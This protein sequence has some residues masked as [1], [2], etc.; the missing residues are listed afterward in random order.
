MTEELRDLMERVAAHAPGGVD[1][2][3]LWARARRSRRRELVIAPI[4]AI[5]VVALVV[6][7]VIGAVG[8]LHSSTVE[9][10]APTHRHGA[11]EVPSRIY[12]MPES[13]GAVTTDLALGTLAAVYLPAGQSR[14][15]A[16][17]AVTGA[18]H[19]LAL[20]GFADGG[21][22]SFALSP[23]G[24]A[25]AYA[26]RAKVPK[27]SQTK[28]V[29]SGIA[30]VEL[31]DG[32]LTRYRFDQGKG[33]QVTM[34][35]WSPNGRWLAF[36]YGVAS[37]LTAGGAT[38]GAW[39]VG[40]MDTNASTADAGVANPGDAL[41]TMPG[42]I[43]STNSAVGV[44]NDGTVI[45]TA[46]DVRLWNPEQKMRRF[47]LP[48]PYRNGKFA[49]AATG[50]LPS[51]DGQHVV[52]TL[53]AAQSPYVL[54][55]AS[56]QMQLLSGLSKATY[57]AFGWVGD[58]IAGTYDSAADRIDLELW[59][60]TGKEQV[61]GSIDQDATRDLSIATGLMDA[62]RPTASFPAPSWAPSGHPW[63][64]WALGGAGVVVLAGLVLIVRR[65]LG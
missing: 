33:V 35:A 27:K 37:K 28:A 46:Y 13:A 52:I 3:D 55:A 44:T 7:V 47:D 20:P 15:V 62:H 34:P 19:R 18:Y 45:A 29:P 48:E 8:G 26:W 10:A 42:R 59:P 31:D 9:P 39:R 51:A 61:V 50:L 64:P 38:Y 23:D 58:S 49:R 5:A 65:R 57:T 63:L 30:V 56:G 4:A 43:G 60:P 40:L 41:L 32:Y 21:A 25:L 6:G 24:T 2:Q 11:A 12:A 22:R 16:V 1:D 54:D 36:D 53:G 17:S 14:P